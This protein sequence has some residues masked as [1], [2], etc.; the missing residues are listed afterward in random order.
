MCLLLVILLRAFVILEY[1]FLIRFNL[2]LFQVLVLILVPLSDSCQG[3]ISQFL[4][5]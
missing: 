1:I 4:F 3:N 2:F 5:N